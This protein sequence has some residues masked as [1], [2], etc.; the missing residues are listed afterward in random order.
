M[1]DRVSKEQRS[2]NMA[3][4]KNKNTEPELVVRKILHRLGYR[5]RIHRR[6]LPGYP[7]IVLPRHRKAIFVHG[8]FWHSHSCP[9]GKRPST[10]A[11]FWNAKLDR[12]VARDEANQRKLES[13]GWKVLVLW[14][15]ELEIAE[16][17][18]KLSSYMTGG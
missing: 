8:C 12:N 2:A 1:A 10:R 9:R 3:R 11:E 13:L 4:V 17:E 15:C 14:E 7:D 6:D 18:R 16:L 5:F